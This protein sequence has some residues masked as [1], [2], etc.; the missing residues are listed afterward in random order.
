MKMKRGTN[1]SWEV[2]RYKGDI[3]LYAHCNCGFEYSCSSS[4]R[5]EDGTW[6]LKQAITKIYRYCP[7]CGAKKKWYNDVPRKM[8]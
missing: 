2:R 6:S 3:A 1:H 5:N 7:N 4:I 8:F